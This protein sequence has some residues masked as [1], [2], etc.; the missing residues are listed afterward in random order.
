MSGATRIKSHLVLKVARVHH[1]HSA[2]GVQLR[3]KLLCGT[4]VAG[5]ASPVCLITS[6]ELSAH[7]T[8][9]EGVNNAAGAV[10]SA[11]GLVFS[12]TGIRV[13]AVG[14][15]LGSVG[16]DINPTLITIGA[17]DQSRVA[18]GFSIAPSIIKVCH[19]VLAALNK[20]QSCASVGFV[21]VL[22]FFRVSRGSLCQPAL[23][24]T[25]SLLLRLL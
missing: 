22:H 1:V 23:Y 24:Q 4:L 18:V 20:Q 2:P 13:G 19:P 12:P 10:L 25:L 6:R 11:Q 7:L 5:A 9:S 21:H 16:L 3:H 14:A 8:R 15:V 17:A